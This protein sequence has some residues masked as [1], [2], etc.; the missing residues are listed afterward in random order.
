MKKYF[1]PFL[2]AL[3]LPLACNIIEEP[4]IE[5]GNDD[6]QTTNLIISASS[7][8]MTKAVLNEDNSVSFVEADALSVF[9]KEYENRKFTVKELYPDGSADFEGGVGSTAGPMPV[10]FPYQE[11]AKYE[12]YGPS[13]ANLYKIY[14]TVPVEQKAVEGSFDPAAAFSFG[15]A[16]YQKDGIAATTLSNKC[17]LVKFTMPEGSYSKVTLSVASGA[18]SGESYVDVKTEGLSDISPI[19]AA[20]SVSICGKID[21]GKTYYMSV[22]PC[23]AEKGITVRLYDANGDLCGE[24]STDK[25]VTFT[26][27]RILNIGTLPLADVSDDWLGEGTQASPYIIATPAHLRKLSVV[28]NKRETA[29][30]YAGKYFKQIRDIDMD[31]EIITIGNYADRYQ[32]TDWKE[33][34]AFNANYDGG[35]YTISNYKLKFITYERTHYLAGLFNIISNATISNLNLKP[36]L[37][38]NANKYLIEG[39]DELTDY[40]YIGFLAG[41]AVGPCTISNCRS[42]AGDYVVNANDEGFEIEPSQTVILGGIVG[43]TTANYRCE[44]NIKNCTNEANLTILNGRHKDVVGGIIG[45]NYGT[46][47]FEYVDRCRNKGNITARSYNTGVDLEVFAGGIVGR[48]TD[49]ASDV[50]FRFSNCVN[51]GIIC[52][53]SQSSEYACAGGIVGSHDSDGWMNLDLSVDEPWAYNCL[54]KGEVYAE[55]LNGMSTIGYDAC[56]GGIFGYCFDYDTVLALC[57]NVGQISASGSPVTGPIC[58]TKGDHR[59][60][61]WLKTDEFWEY[62]PKEC[63]NCHACIGFILGNGTGSDTPEFVRLNGYA[64]D[65]ASSKSLYSMTQWDQAKWAAAAP[66]TGISDLNWDLPDHQN[67]LDLIF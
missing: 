8:A 58:G 66:W 49:D 44:I 35:G 19:E 52:A 37:Y 51:E 54:N 34:T 57:V 18:I 42:L 13:S 29:R 28:F 33:P 32:D 64:S 10:M 15:M 40:Y 22:I 27:G 31:G 26:K 48:V 25:Q 46:G 53:Q 67:N 2:A 56:A 12:H 39:V 55:C 14:F 17:A 6:D 3:V 65:D 36:A 5:P 16:E 23:I 38:D 45:T 41:Q 61:Y 43:R 21:G 9:D 63:T 30:P 11:E 62:V 1:L 47:Q 4:C 24:K 7:S 60:C 20:K 59:W 50:A